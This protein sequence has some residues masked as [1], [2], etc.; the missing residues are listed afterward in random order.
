MSRDD[1]LGDAHLVNINHSVS[2]RFQLLNL[3]PCR[4]GQLTY[5]CQLILIEYLSL[6]DLFLFDAVLPVDLPQLIYR[7]LC[8]R[9][10]SSESAAS[11][12]EGQ[13]GPVPQSLSLCKESDMFIGKSASLITTT[14][15]LPSLL[16]RQRCHSSFSVLALVLVSFC[17][18]SHLLV[19]A[20]DE[21][22]DLLQRQQS[23]SGLS[24]L[25]VSIPEYRNKFV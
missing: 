18:T 11:L 1:G 17:N 23:V 7:E 15:P 16:S 14:C 25:T 21:G 3:I 22:G 2:L 6:L 10:T 4:Y 24:V 19:A 20:V 5:F 12:L 8:V 9:K 13:A